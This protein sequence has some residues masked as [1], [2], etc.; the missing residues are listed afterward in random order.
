MFPSLSLPLPFPPPLPTISSHPLPA[1]KQP[2]KPARGLGS[3]VS[4][5]VG[6]VAKRILVY[7]ELENRTCRQNYISHVL[8]TCYIFGYLY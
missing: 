4:S 7:F 6:S 2:W 8:Y 5:P 1:E 3:A